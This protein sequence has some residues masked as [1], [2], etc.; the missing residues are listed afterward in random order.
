MDNKL[1]MSTTPPSGNS[2]TIYCD[3]EVLHDEGLGSKPQVTDGCFVY[4]YVNLKCSVLIFL[5]LKQMAT[6]YFR[7][8]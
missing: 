1:R 3:K 5:D 2:Q 6:V 7:H 8:F 4:N